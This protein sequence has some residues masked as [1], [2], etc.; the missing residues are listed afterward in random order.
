MLPG[1]T[2]NTELGDKTPHLLFQQGLGDYIDA[3]E[4]HCPQGLPESVTFQQAFLNSILEQSEQIYSGEK[5]KIGNTEFEVIMTRHH[6]LDEGRLLV[7]NGPDAFANLYIPVEISLQYLRSMR[8]VLSYF[9]KPMPMMVFPFLPQK[10]NL[11]GSGIEGLGWVQD[12]GPV[13]FQMPSAIDG[14]PGR[15]HGH[16]AHE[17]FHCG[18]SYSYPELYW[19]LFRYNSHLDES[20]AILTDLIL[21]WNEY[22]YR[23]HSPATTMFSNPTIDGFPGGMTQSY[24][25]GATVENILNPGSF[26]EI[27][28]VGF[29]HSAYPKRMQLAM[30]TILLSLGA[31]NPNLVANPQAFEVYAQGVQQAI[32][33]DTP[34][35]LNM[36][37]DS[38]MGH[39]TT[40]IQKL[41][42]IRITKGIVSENDYW[43][44]MLNSKVVNKAEVERV[45][46]CLTPLTLVAYLFYV[47]RSPY[48]LDLPLSISN[49]DQTILDAAKKAAEGLGINP[50]FIDAE[51]LKL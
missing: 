32:S 23:Y 49:Y 33:K 9:G 1:V 28:A 39:I 44:L 45:Y 17:A 11:N 40:V 25:A 51:L 21:S 30:L 46:S 35:P 4:K 10:F 6:P 12:S 16:C 13:I 18:V 19:Q 36:R 47:I 26:N 50:K 8:E 24:M 5:V 29:D 20:L 34:P 7:P 2:N 31:N 42:E 3:S 38:V 41:E 37:R 43:K 15:V 22:N 27:N 14:L 48:D